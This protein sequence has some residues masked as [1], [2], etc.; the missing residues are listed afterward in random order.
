MENL[1]LTQKI[2]DIEALKADIIKTTADI[3]RETALGADNRE[4][5]ASL[6]ALITK[7]YLL[8]E[9]MGI[10]YSAVDLLAGESLKASAHVDGAM[11]LY[12]HLNHRK[13]K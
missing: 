10:G 6:G 12:R 5:T 1:N 11:E 7:A 8:G 9:R 2:K 3:I 4:I 13:G